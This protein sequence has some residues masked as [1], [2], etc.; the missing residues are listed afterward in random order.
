[1][2]L[3]LVNYC[4]KFIQLLKIYIPTNSRRIRVTFPRKQIS[5]ANHSNLRI[6]MDKLVHEQGSI[7]QNQTVEFSNQT[8]EL[9]RII[10]AQRVEIEKS[11]SRMDQEVQMPH[12]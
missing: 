3:Q 4:N 7:L 2:N 1:M 11:N 10:N 8:K 6:E 5:K 12:L 9:K